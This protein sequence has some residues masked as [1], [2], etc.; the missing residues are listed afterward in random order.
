MCIPGGL[1]WF[2]LKEYS[3]GRIEVPAWIS[4]PPQ[5]CPEAGSWLRTSH[6]SPVAGC[7][8]LGYLGPLIPCHLRVFFT[9]LISQFS[10]YCYW[11]QETVLLP[12][13]MTCSRVTACVPAYFML[14]LLSDLSVSDFHVQIWWKT[15]P[16]LM[17]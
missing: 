4:S 14:V 7:P 13:A 2:S 1:I 5:A 12:L 3:V 17:N 9:E 8:A 11:E 10:S 16:G 6:R 15:K